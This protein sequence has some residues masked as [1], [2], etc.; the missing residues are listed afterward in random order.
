MSLETAACAWAAAARVPA[1]GSVTAG[2]GA[3]A[4]EMGC[5]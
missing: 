5:L 2:G 1:S 4:N 3:C